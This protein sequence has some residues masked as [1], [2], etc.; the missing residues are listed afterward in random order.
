[1]KNL[2]LSF[3]RFTNTCFLILIF[4][5]LSHF[6][7]CTL[8][9]EEQKTS[10][11]KNQDSIK[12]FMQDYRTAWK[13]GDSTAV[14]EKISSNIILYLPGQTAQP[15]VGKKAVQE[16]WFPNTKK[17]YPILTYEIENEE[18]GV[19]SHLAYYQGLSKLTWFTLDRGV[20]RDTML[21]ISE[22]T[23]LLKKEEEQWKIYRIM[24]NRKATNYS[25]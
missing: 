18:I 16:F 8:P 2:L 7:G 5:F 11:T 13:K 15:I 9:S 22:F 1:M 21:S 23:T 6:L 3:F 25:R 10:E 4:G 20:G 24:Y 17:T 19:S 12:T 14:L